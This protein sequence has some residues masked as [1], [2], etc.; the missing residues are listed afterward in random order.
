M[1]HDEHTHE[2][3]PQRLATIVGTLR[4]VERALLKHVG[5]MDGDKKEGYQ[6]ALYHVAQMRVAW[7]GTCACD[8]GALPERKDGEWVCADCEQ[9]IEMVVPAP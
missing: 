6:L 3:T 8:D 4:S 1:N 5:G 9:P 7:A 2:L